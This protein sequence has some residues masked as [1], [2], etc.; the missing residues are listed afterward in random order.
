MEHKTY[1]RPSTP[2]NRPETPDSRP[3]T[4]EATPPPRRRRHGYTIPE[5]PEVEDIGPDVEDGKK[6][7]YD[8]IRASRTKPGAE[9]SGGTRIGQF[10]RFSTRRKMNQTRSRTPESD[11]PTDRGGRERPRSADWSEA[12]P[13]D[14]S[15][16][17]PE[18]PASAAA[19]ETPDVKKD[20]DYIR[21]LAQERA[22]KWWWGGDRPESAPPDYERN[23]D[24]THYNTT[25]PE[26]SSGY[27][28][29]PKTEKPQESQ[30]SYRDSFK[31]QTGPS[32]TGYSST[33]PSNTGPSGPA[34]SGAGFSD[35]TNSSSYTGYTE[36]NPGSSSYTEAP[37]GS[38]SYTG[39]PPGSSSYTGAT[40]GSSS[41]T[42]ATPGSSSTNGTGQDSSY[43]EAGGYKS[44]FFGSSSKPSATSDSTPLKEPKIPDPKSTDKTQEEI[45][46]EISDALEE[47]WKLPEHQRKKIIKRILLKWHPDK[48]IGNE[49]F[50]TEITQHIQYDI[51]RLEQ[52]LPRG[53]ATTAGSG[54]FSSGNPFAG[55]S[56]F[57]KNFQNAYQYFY[58]QMNNRA[59]EHKKNRERYQDNF[60]KTKDDFKSSKFNVP[61]SF[62]K[63]NPQ[64]TQAFQFFR[65]AQEDLK[66][67]DNDYNSREPAFEWVCM[68]AHQ[69]AEKSLKAAQFMVDAVSSFSHDL[70]T[71]AATMDDNTIRTLA[72]RLQSIVG[73]ANKFYNPDPIDF[74]IIPHEEFTREK[75]LN[76]SIIATEILEKVRIMMGIEKNP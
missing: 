71:L 35:Y 1:A 3:G 57:Q 58:E 4:P 17:P 60:S 2:D 51:A 21:R 38:S 62:S 44:R 10:S 42:G 32:S 6:S 66:A 18:R 8:Y 49:Q 31:P 40:P 64:P 65:Q 22:Q 72:I 68:K 54:F 14:G 20:P 50:A 11:K 15:A 70:P 67:A 41:Y 36:A 47:A 59:K 30:S 13:D 29:I 63:T 45:M 16:P 25:P 52:G 33:G 76:A 73:D 48:N 26:E 56:E 27:S 53:G 34:P 46:D 5:E 7:A 69:A 23:Y 39:A 24:S 61:P 28:D 75:A 43:Q 19:G 12:V 9:A 37:P 55:S 74:V